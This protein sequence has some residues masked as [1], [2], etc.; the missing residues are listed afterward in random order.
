[1]DRVKLVVVA[2]DSSEESLVALD[3]A[4]QLGSAFG[5]RV[6]AVHAVGLLEE[7]GYQRRIDL[8]G[9]VDQAR[10]RAPEAS[11]VHVDCLAEDGPA[12]G[13][14]LRVTEREHADLIVI[15]SR[16]LGQAERLLGSVSEA[17]LTHARVPVLIVPRV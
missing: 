11:H 3:W 1:V 2:V 8:A 10:A 15:G 13:V 9:I 14:I 4:L 16:G 7:G 17:V 6:L 5:C 12:S